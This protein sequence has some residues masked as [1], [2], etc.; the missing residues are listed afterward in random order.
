M[1]TSNIFVGRNAELEQFRKVLKQP[2]GQAVL[3]VGHEGMGKTEL[4]NEMARR[5]EKSL[6]FGKGLKAKCWSIRGLGAGQRDSKQ[7]DSRY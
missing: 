5:A 3:V 1:S 2:Q 6:L 4:I 7:S